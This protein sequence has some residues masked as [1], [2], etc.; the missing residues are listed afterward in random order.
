MPA[1]DRPRNLAI[2]VRIACI[3]P[4]ST[5]EMEALGGEEG[6]RSKW[7]E[8]AI[9]VASSKGLC[10][11]QENAKGFR[12]ETVMNDHDGHSAV[13]RSSSRRG[14]SV[15][16][17]EGQKRGDDEEDI[18]EIVTAA[19]KAAMVLAA[20]AMIGESG[21]QSAQKANCAILEGTAWSLAGRSHREGVGGTLSPI[22]DQ[23]VPAFF[24]PC[25]DGISIL[26]A[27]KRVCVTRGWSSRVTRLSGVRSSFRSIR[28]CE[29]FG[30]VESC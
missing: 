29:E 28:T 14:T 27:C 3:Y 7:A 25:P 8:L 11:L 10:T 16:E 23:R 5:G 2:F 9:E 21:A 20:G 19:E 22:S 6:N 24:F 1:L 26:H 17:D 4:V 12:K 15:E 18:E 13:F 30:Q